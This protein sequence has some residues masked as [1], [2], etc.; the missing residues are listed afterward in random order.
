[1]TRINV[2]PPEEL[3]DQHLIAE[4][5]E[6]RL[7]SANLIRSLKSKNGIVVDKLPKAFTLNKGHCSF[8][9]DKGKYLHNRYNLLKAE[10]VAR[11]FSPQFDFPRSNW[12]DH[13]YNDWQPT[14]ADMNIVRDRIKLRVSE[15]PNWYRY[16]GEKIL[17]QPLPA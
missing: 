17:A 7:H 12:P 16:K 5:R 14:E 6:I 10:M 9:Y 15:K 4:Y 11:G 13:L 1:M 8:F 3:Y 2:V